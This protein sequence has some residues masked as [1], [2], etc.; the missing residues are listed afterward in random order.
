M[1]SVSP[2]E[3]QA[4]TR[5]VWTHYKKQGRHDLAWRKQIDPYSIVVS[6]IMLQQTQVARVESYYKTWKQSFPSWRALARSP[7]SQAL[8]HWQGL[9]YNRRGK[10][11]H[12]IAKTVTTNNKG[13]FPT[14]YREIL[15]L[16]GIGP[17]TASAVMAFSY[18]KPAVLLET[19]IR[20]A[21]IHHF[22]NNE[23]KV[24]EQDIEK[25][26]QAC[27]KNGTKAYKNSREW[28][29]ALMDYGS[30]LKQTVGNLNR[31]STTYA[32]QSR[33]EGS[34]RQ[35]RSQILRYIL[36]KTLVTT[37][38]IKEASA[39]TRAGEIDKLLN[40]LSQERMI[41]KKGRNWKVHG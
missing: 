8:S 16:P 37:T 40:E 14:E 24:S 29:W 27:L 31:K 17:Y 20:T 3:I 1:K 36:E 33:F 7:L 39:G 12:E 32:K 19:N 21:V 26:L 10:Y 38:Q 5:T 9:G 11:L 2:R 22:F 23:K 35:L 13:K 30:H 41:V 6:E 18:N 4:F 15:A 25:I 28:Y 34:R